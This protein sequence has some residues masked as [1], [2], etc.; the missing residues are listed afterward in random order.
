VDL[1]ARE[2]NMSLIPAFEIGIWNAWILQVVFY[3]SMFIPDF[4]LD[5]EA[6]N[7]AKRMSM[8]ALY[9]KIEKLLALSTHVVIMP[10][11]FIYSIFL[12]LKIGSVWL[13]VGLPIFAVS[14]L[15]SVTTLFNIASSSID[16]PVTKGAYRFSRH[17]MYFSGFLMFISIAISCASWVVF[18]CGVLWIG[19]W[20]IVVPTEERILIEKYGDAYRKYAARTPRWIGIPKRQR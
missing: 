14:L 16:K 17:P 20:Q 10:L 15:M 5:K 3:L 1:I 11:V 4:F 6:K 13:Y 19:L 8:F 18:L 7:R 12:P 9:K 2:V